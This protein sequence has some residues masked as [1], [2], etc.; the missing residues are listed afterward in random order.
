M[1]CTHCM[2]RELYLKIFSE[3][4]LYIYRGYVRGPMASEDKLDM[5]EHIHQDS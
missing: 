1:I 3:S 2:L 4:S 5:I